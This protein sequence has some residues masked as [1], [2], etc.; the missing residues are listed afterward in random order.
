M[1]TL[2]RVLQTIGLMILPFA[3]VSELVGQV[4][5]GKSMLIALGGMILFQIGLALQKTTEG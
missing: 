5:L 3:I 1:R 4:G 2:G